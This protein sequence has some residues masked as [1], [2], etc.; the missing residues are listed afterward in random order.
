M[1]G[2]FAVG[3]KTNQLRHLAVDGSLFMPDEGAPHARTWM[4]FVANEYIWT[5]KQI[6]AVKRDLVRIAT[7]IAKY[8]PVSMLVSP[9]DMAEAQKL[10][11]DLTRYQ[12][13][14]ELIECRT[15]D[16]WV[17]DTGPTFV[18]DS[19]GKKYGVNFNF[20]GWG[21]KQEHSFDARVADFITNQANATII[22]SNI[23]LEG[24][25]FEI[26]G[27]G[28]A[29]LTKS[30]VLN[31]NRNPNV[32]QTE[33]EKE[34]ERLLGIQ[35]VIWL[36]GI[37]GKD[38]TDGHVDF[39]AR[40]SQKEKVLVSRDNYQQS[41]DYNVT[42]KN[43]EVLQEATDIDDNP[44][45]VT[46]IDAPDVINE[47]FGVRDF[48][49]G[50]I[51]YYL[52]NGAVIMQKFWDEVADQNAKEIIAQAFPDRVIEQIAIDA[53]A[54]GGGSIHCAT[55]QEPLAQKTETT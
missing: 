47:N 37:K 3:C 48:A 17:R 40:F 10:L 25:S 39:Y 18:L 29:I 45:D 24:G 15:D 52:C 54:S 41:H 13:P 2:G 20:N 38:I 42:R 35:K 49:A 5:R 1:A 9:E 12:Y 32:S 6:P 53:I 27:H 23:V 16:L 19:E 33:V 26:D 34:L 28:T 46:V 7:A 4:A 55:Q 11:G 36:D 31:D 43:I 8:E 14:I 50:Y 51:G 44:L 21:G 30:A 22:P